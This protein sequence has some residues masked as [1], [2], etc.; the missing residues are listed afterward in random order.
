MPKPSRLKGRSNLL[1]AAIK[2]AGSD[3][4]LARLLGVHRQAVS[5]WDD[6]PPKRKYWAMKWVADA[7]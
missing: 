3:A 2:K 1:R 5:Q 6:F 7:R 4:A